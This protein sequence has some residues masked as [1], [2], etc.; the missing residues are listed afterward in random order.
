[1][2]WPKLLDIGIE[3]I[4]KADFLSVKQKSDI[5]YNNAA[6]LPQLT[7]EEIDRHHGVK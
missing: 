4:E 6:R 2:V 1:M 7:K 3:T 5:L